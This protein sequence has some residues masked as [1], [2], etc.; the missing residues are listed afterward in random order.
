MIHQNSIESYAK[1]KPTIEMR[2]SLIREALKDL[3]I[4]TDRQIMEHLG[5]TDMNDVRPQITEGV[6]AGIFIECEKR[7][8]NVTGHKVR[9]TR[10]AGA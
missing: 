6:T 1:V 8:C 9:C 10:L 2:R 4:A 3:C 7:V 5:F